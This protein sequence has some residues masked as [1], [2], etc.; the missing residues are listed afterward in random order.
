M[1]TSFTYKIKSCGEIWPSCRTPEAI[2]ILL[3]TY[4]CSLISWNLQNIYE[5][6]KN[7]TDCGTSNTS[8]TDKTESKDEECI[9]KRW[10]NNGKYY[11]RYKIKY[12]MQRNVLGQKKI[13]YLIK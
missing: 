11:I 8:T 13:N 6:N 9:N 7:I 1:P 3:E 10:R 12:H 4:S 2:E 5:K